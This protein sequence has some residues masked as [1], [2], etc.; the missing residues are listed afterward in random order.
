MSLRA[1]TA[2]GDGVCI[3]AVCAE[4]G[5]KSSPPGEPWMSVG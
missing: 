4:A 1:L 3:E 2:A 5:A